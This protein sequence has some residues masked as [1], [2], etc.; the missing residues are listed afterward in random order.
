MPAPVVV[1][2]PCAESPIVKRRRGRPRKVPGGE[3]RYCLKL[4]A[5]GIS[6]KGIREKLQI[7]YRSWMR[8]LAEEDNRHQLQRVRS[9]ALAQQDE[10][11]Y[12]AALNGNVAAYNAVRA[13]F[14]CGRRPWQKV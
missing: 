7:S 5:L 9:N 10:S 1:E 12:R 4:A 6:D 8:W 13:H 2:E 3:F 14:L 11:M